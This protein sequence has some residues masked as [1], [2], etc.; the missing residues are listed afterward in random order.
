MRAYSREISL[1]TSFSNHERFN[2]ISCMWW[3]EHSFKLVT[4][5]V[6]KRFHL[7][8]SILELARDCN[9]DVSYFSLWRLSTQR[10][11]FPMTWI[12]NFPISLFSDLHFF[13]FDESFLQTCH[14][15]DC[16]GVFVIWCH[17]F[18][19]ELILTPQNSAPRNWYGSFTRFDK[20]DSLETKGGR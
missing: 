7:F 9:K 20:I 4:V 6:S 2:L 3:I 10:G 5:M 14:G 8:K 11:N 12:A 17:C 16:I 15:C 19:S 13:T 18:H 1:F